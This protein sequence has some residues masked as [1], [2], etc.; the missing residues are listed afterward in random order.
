MDRVKQLEEI[1]D[2]ALSIF[3]RKNKDYGDSFATFGPVGVLV[4]M[5]DKIK[6]ALS[7]SATG[8][9]LVDDEGLRDTLMDL[10]NYS[11]MAIMLLD[12][13]SSG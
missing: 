10:A 2:E 3:R 4:R 6:R 12:E 5:E 13:K 1:Q 9:T 8:V 7:I 11:M